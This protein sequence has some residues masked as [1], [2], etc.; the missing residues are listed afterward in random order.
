[1]LPRTWQRQQQRQREGRALACLGGGAGALKLG[2][3]EEA[4]LAE[5][6]GDLGGKEGTGVVSGVR[7][8]MYRVARGKAQADLDVSP[9]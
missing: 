9:R 7:R 8:R 3:E 6:A 1:M 2:G 4:L 5:R